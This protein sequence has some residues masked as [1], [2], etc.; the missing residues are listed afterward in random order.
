MQAVCAGFIFALDIANL[1]I[2]SGRVRNALV[3]GAETMS[4]L[5]DW[6]DRSTAILFG[7]G[8]GAVILQGQTATESGII[9][10]VTS[11]A[12]EYRNLLYT[13]GGV[14]TTGL[15]GNVIRVGGEVY[16]HAVQKMGDAVM[17]L[18]ERG[19]L[20]WNDIDWFI[21]HQA[22]IRIIQAIQ[23]RSG[24]PWEKIITT[25]SHHANT[26]AA[27]I[28]LAMADAVKKGLFQP[29]QLIMLSAIGGG[30]AWGACSIR[31]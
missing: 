27:S 31:W 18:L 19:G 17:T 4:R 23:E 12:G 28:P 21:P 1:Y 11:S 3:I 2:T 9:D 15:A 7:D 20:N 30:L 13:S 25:V 8:A 26:S 16:R 22:N 24:L 10:V 29:G 5:I 14:S 6:G